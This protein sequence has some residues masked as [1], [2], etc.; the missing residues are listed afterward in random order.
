MNHSELPV[1]GKVVLNRQLISNHYLMTVHL[2][3][4]VVNPLP[5]QFIMVMLNRSG[6]AFLGRPFSIYNYNRRRNKAAIDIL[7]QVVGR[8]TRLMAELERGDTLNIF[9]P[10]GKSFG[11]FPQAG[12][13]ILIAGGMGVAPISYLASYYKKNIKRFNGNIICYSGA[14]T[15]DHLLGMDGLKATCSSV[16]VS[17]DDGSAGFHGAVTELFAGELPGYVPDQCVLYACGPSPMLKK[18]S[19]I[20]KGCEIPCQ[21]LLEQRMACGV[22]ACLGCVVEVIHADEASQ[23]A[24]VCVDGPVF[25]IRNINWNATLSEP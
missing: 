24:R 22:G 3:E 10:H 12:N 8:G 19:E 6:G 15:S 1:P 7:Y 16:H 11:L 17:T 25:D 20:L 2:A 5:G 23:Y 9:G 4:P 14:R 18:L 13:V 21:V